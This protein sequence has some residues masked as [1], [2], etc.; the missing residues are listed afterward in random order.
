[1]LPLVTSRRCQSQSQEGT[2]S[3]SAG[4]QQAFYGGGCLCLLLTITLKTLPHLKKQLGHPVRA[5][6][7]CR[8][9]SLTQVLLSTPDDLNWNINPQRARGVIAPSS[10]TT[11]GEGCGPAGD[12]AREE[13][14]MS[15]WTRSSSRRPPLPLQHRRRDVSVFFCS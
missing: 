4:K 13:A 1:V 11:T 10:A 6:V 9:S 7:V 14:M 3:S 12:R 5:P 2:E 15:G 8:L